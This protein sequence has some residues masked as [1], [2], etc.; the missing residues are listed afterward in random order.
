[1]DAVKEYYDSQAE[2]EWIRLNNPYTKIEFD[3]TN[4]LIDKYFPKD[5]EILDIGAGPG[6]YSL[7]MLKKGYKVSLLDISINELKIAENKITESG[8]KAENYFCKSA[9]QLNEFPENKYDGV[10]L[11]GPLYHIHEEEIRTKVLKDT[12]RILKK[13]GTALISYINSWGALRAA[14][15]EFP[16]VFND[17]KHFQGYFQ[18]NLKFSAE[19][20]FTKTFFTTPLHA[21]Q[22]VEGAGFEVISYAAAEGF[23]SGLMPQMQELSLNQPE[24][25]KNFVRAAVESCE[26]PQYR[27]SSE[28]LHII[29][30]K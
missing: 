1:M 22:E 15:H 10:L 7:E 14:P 29:V 12:Y 9:I 20:S 13:G 3:S 4:Y 26:F 2:K 17:I 18:G 28:H 16:D 30:K 25:Y 19:E 6:R 11:M 24:I 8:L 21:L 27:D 23:L 5:G